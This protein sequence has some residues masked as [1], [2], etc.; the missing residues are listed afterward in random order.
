MAVRGACWSWASARRAD[1]G[2]A[3]GRWQAGR[4]QAGR[5]QAGRWQAGRLPAGVGITNIDASRAMAPARA[6]YIDMMR[7]YFHSTGVPSWR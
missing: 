4:W 7:G 3:A 6:K 1:A 2:A 5:W